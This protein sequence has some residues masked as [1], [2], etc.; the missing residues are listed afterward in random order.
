[1]K[2][3]GKENFGKIFRYITY[4]KYTFTMYNI[5]IFEEDIFSVFYLKK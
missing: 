2:Y 5:A 1:M 3:T 4:T